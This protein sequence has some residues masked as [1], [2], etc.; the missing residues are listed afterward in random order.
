MSSPSERIR[1]QQHET[2]DRF[3]VG[4]RRW[5]ELVMGSIAPVGE[6]LVRTSAV[7]EDSH[8]LDVAAG[9]GEPGLSVAALAPRGRVVV[10][11]LSEQMLE[12]EADNAARRGIS[13]FETR[14]CDAG[15]LPFADDTFDSVTCRFGFMF[16]PDIPGYLAEMVRVAKPGAHISSAVWAGPQGNLWA[17]TIL[18]TI[19]AHVDL[20]PP[21]PDL[22]SLFPCAP[23][24]FMRSTYAAG[25]LHHV[26]ERDVLGEFVFE[27]PQQ[28]WDFMTE[29]A[30]PVV[31]GLAMADDPT[32]ATI[33]DEVL[34]LAAARTGDGEVRFPFHART[35]TGE[36]PS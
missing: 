36:K 15:D 32:K 3:S 2:W 17:T 25:G 1:D 7:R 4:W 24:G 35:I 27:S 6:E 21:D 5:D 19:G 28:Y 18:G 11:D 33:R 26:A 23:D 13:N 20:P 31:A 16:F 29:V 34:D 10:T 12:V 22:P 8:H 9:T 30:A 14:A